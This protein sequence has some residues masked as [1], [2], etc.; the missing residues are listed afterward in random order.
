[1]CSFMCQYRM[2]IVQPH[3]TCF[4]RTSG[5]LRTHYCHDC[6]T[7]CR[8]CLLCL[9]ACEAALRLQLPAQAVS[10]PSAA[11]HAAHSSNG[12]G[13]AAG[14]EPL[15]HGWNGS[16]GAVSGAHGQTQSSVYGQDVVFVANDWHA[17]AHI[18]EQAG[19]L[20]LPCELTVASSC[21][22][23][24]SPGRMDCPCVTLCL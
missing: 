14:A 23:H 18:V 4:Q 8:Y 15:A 16:A 22:F 13:P 21:S 5:R 17:G 19:T 12:A 3:M 6:R 9:A 2:Q 7:S 1:M 20:L 10:R 24:L 11:M